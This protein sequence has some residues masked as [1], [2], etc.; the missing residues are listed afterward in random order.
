MNYF[1]RILIL[2]ITAS[3]ATSSW[4]NLSNTASSS[5]KDAAAN[6]YTATSNTVIVTVI[7]VPAIT[8]PSTA[9]G[10]VGVAFSYQITASM[11]ATNFS[12]SG[13]LPSGISLNASSGLL[14]GT[15][16]VSGTFT[17]TI[18]A[19]NAAGTGTSSLAITV[20]PA[21]T[22]S[23]QKSA[24]PTSVKAG[25]TVTFTIQYQNTTLGSATNVVIN[26]V[27]PTGSTLKAG[28][29][30]AGGT[31]AGNTITWTLGT[32]AGNTSGSVSFQVTAN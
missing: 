14:S 6:T 4:A 11:T 21:A 8:S 1:K 32:V 20:H 26:D 16:T 7:S 3:L 28:S 17:V 19:T 12:V 23:L 2:G 15:P 10:D 5:Y 22:V 30:T 31:L 24:S 27:I 13:S 25:D 9:T 29:I 18:G